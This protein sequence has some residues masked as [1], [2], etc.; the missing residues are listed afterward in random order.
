MRKYWGI[1]LL[2]GMLLFAGCKGKQAV[3][4][5]ENGKVTNVEVFIAK[6]DYFV[7][8]LTL[9]VT[10]SPWREASVALTQGGRV[11]KILA[12]KGAHVR[13]GQGLLETDTDTFRANFRTAEASLA[14]QKSE[15]AR[16]TNLFEAGSV[17]EAVFDAAKLQLAQAESAYD[18]AKK[19]LDDATLEAPFGGVITER[20][21]EVGNILGAGTPAFRI[22]EMDRVKIQAGIPEKYIADFRNGSVV[23][24]V[25]DAIPGREFPGKITYLAPEAVTQTRTFPAEIAID[26]PGGIIRAGIV[27]N[28]RIQR[29]VYP[30][31][32]LVPLDAL[33]E[34]QTG[35]K[36]F[37]A[38]ADSTADEREVA[39]GSGSGDMILITSGLS[40]GERV[41]TKGQ[42]GISDGEKVRV[43]SEYTG[44][45]GAAQ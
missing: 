35:R 16:N 17:S 24:V 30:N 22:I 25:F 21:A 1:T 2:A 5:V 4:T 41:V 19:Q 27:G 42:H 32:I 31:A 45:G 14:Y 12:D 43:T 36:L 10:V 37:V 26:N 18:I 8:Y 29:K 39:V 6:R 7:D 20:N 13:M 38:L 40:A 44:T 9:P 28:A 3:G 23:K 33:V 15:F 11:T 34:T